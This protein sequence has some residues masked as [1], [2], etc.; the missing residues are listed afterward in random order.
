MRFFRRRAWSMILTYITVLL[1]IALI[2]TGVVLYAIYDFSSAAVIS[3]FVEVIIINFILGLIILMSESASSFKIAW[4]F[5]V[6]M[7][8]IIGPTFYILFAHKYTSSRQKKYFKNYFSILKNAEQLESINNIA[9]ERSSS[10]YKAAK[11]LENSTNAVLYGHSN[12]TY[13][14]FGENMFPQMLEDLKKA[15]HYIYLEFFII[16]KG[17]MW[18]SIYEILKEKAKQG[19][20]IRVIWD[21]V[22]NVAW[23]PII[24]EDELAKNG[25][26]GRVYGKVKPFVDARLSQRDH[27]KIMVIDGY[28]GYTGGVNLA[29]EYINV[30]N[31][32]GVWKDN[33]I[34]VE[35]E[36]VY[37]YTL[38]FLSTW[39]TNFDPHKVIDY[40]YYKPKKFMPEED[41]Y[42]SNDCLVLPYGDVPYT[43]RN[44]GESTYV[45]ILNNANS[46]VYITT[47]YLIPSENLINSLTLAALSG[48]DV[49]I[50]T[51]GI[52]D[53]KI[54][55]QLTR[56]YYG[57]LLKA[58]VKIYEFTDGFIHAKTFVSD[59]E[60]ST[61][62]TIN[63][64]FRSLYL[65][66]ENGTLIIGDGIAKE[67]KEDYL[68]TLSRCD[69]IDYEK[70]RKWRRRKGLVWHILRI[71]S[72]FL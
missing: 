22:G 15:K 26:K 31:R 46:Y 68:K 55:Y 59:D 13:F 11:Y 42:I 4:L 54:V 67:I 19:V 27:R 30:E 37:G 44:A 41:R 3:V 18:D 60:L 14:P 16:T 32:F 40:D 39:M 66:S 9:K 33:A 52:P 17:K 1:E 38:L 57:V 21:D 49:R 2:I 6:G 50:I 25:I 51:P 64:D 34:R 72:P 61:V 62:G 24:Y 7:I 48:I 63:L 53:K 69:E 20:D 58:G 8:P 65:H 45:S 10:G 35:G 23:R 70:W 12:V 29:D 56:S 71:F 5:I 43:L 28:I 47:P 36:A